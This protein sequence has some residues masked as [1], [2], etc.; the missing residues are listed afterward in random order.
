[1]KSKSFAINL[2]SP[3]YSTLAKLGQSPKLSL[4]EGDFKI[5]SV[6]YSIV[7]SLQ[8]CKTSCKTV[9]YLIQYDKDVDYQIIL[10]QIVNPKVKLIPCLSTG[11]E[12][13]VKQLLQDT[14]HQDLN[15]EQKN[16]FTIIEQKNVVTII[17]DLGLS[18]HG[19][20]TVLF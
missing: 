19:M 7:N 8:D 13:F 11:L 14:S 1:M 17:E 3:Y 9:I 15:I 18:E 2:K 16:V 12:I 4:L 5:D 20:E 6:L 10:F